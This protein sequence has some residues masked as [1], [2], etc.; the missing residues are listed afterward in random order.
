MKNQWL[1]IHKHTRPPSVPRETKIP[2]FDNYTPLLVFILLCILVVQAVSSLSIKSPTVDESNHLTFGYLAL[3]ERDYRHGTDHP[4]FV[5][6]FAAL[7]LLSLDLPL[8]AIY[9]QLPETAWFGFGSDFLF[10]SQNNVDQIFFLSRLPIV[11]LSTLLGFYVFLWAK[12]LYGDRAGLLALILFVF[13]PNILA[14][15]RLVT[16]DLG[17]TCFI[18]IACFY[19]WTYLNEPSFRSLC[20][21]SLFSGLAL[22]SKFSAVNLF[23]IFFSFVCVWYFTHYRSSRQ[24]DPGLTK[25]KIPPGAA[26]T[27][28]IHVSVAFVIVLGIISIAYGLDPDPIARY[29]NGL[30]SLQEIY[31]ENKPPRLYYLGG[32]FYTEP[33]WFFPIAAFLLK[34]PVPTMTLLVWSA[35]LARRVG[36][37]IFN[38]LC[39]L[40]PVA[41][42]IF[43][44]FFDSEH[45]GL[46][47]L[48]P[49]FPFLFVFIS[50][51][52]ILTE[53]LISSTLKKKAAIC[54]LALLVTWYI[55]SSIKTYPDYLTYF[56]EFA[57]GPENGIHYLDDSNIDWGQ[58]LKR[59]KPVMDQLGIEKIKL[60][61]EGWADPKYY[62]IPAEEINADDRHF[63]PQSGY[64]AISAHYLIR[65]RT[66]PTAFG[67][68]IAWKE[69][70]FEPIT[71]I[72]NTIYIFY[73]DPS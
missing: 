62:K 18:F 41:A 69:K 63:G 43:S 71:V 45:V 55:V 30:N 8:P 6:S 70:E 12:K 40:I 34:T 37:N 54:S 4:P 36:V 39:I 38:E 73:F 29:I 65:L 52:A 9:F 33:A 42:I 17:V 56:N 35:L 15:S 20:L 26:R 28:F 1:S 57:G 61:Y 16:T 49:I 22:A 27:L 48:L 5:K 2:R 47:R 58:D 53:N 23:P 72:G 59:L 11:F 7:P 21:T 19:F 25:K 46:R 13:S 67:Y 24:N 32:T 3:T 44:S 31:F 50:R 14:H 68:G 66:I 10:Q 60:M 51:T 64:Y